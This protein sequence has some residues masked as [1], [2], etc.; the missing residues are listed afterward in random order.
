MDQHARQKVGEVLSTAVQDLGKMPFN[1]QSIEIIGRCAAIQTFFTDAKAPS[2]AR[3]VYRDM[4]H[5][6]HRFSATVSGQVGPQTQSALRQVAEL[7]L[8][9]S[10]KAGPA[11]SSLR[12]MSP[13][14]SLGGLTM[15]SLPLEAD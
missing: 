5:D 13:E 3:D 14:V 7:F 15:P 1:K 10:S 6:L 2:L 9:E 8:V 12:S 11:P 4:A